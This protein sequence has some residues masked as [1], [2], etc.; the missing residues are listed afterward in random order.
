MIVSLSIMLALY[1][2]NLGSK[3]NN[4]NFFKLTKQ[5]GVNYSWKVKEPN[6]YVDMIKKLQNGGVEVNSN[7]LSINGLS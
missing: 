6:K 5:G 1:M 2:F 4:K 7:I 3:E